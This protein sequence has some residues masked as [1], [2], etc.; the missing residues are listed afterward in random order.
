[1]RVAVIRFPGSNCDLDVLEALR[2][3]PEVSS[4][5]LWHSDARLGGYDAV[6]LPGGFSYA[7]R[8]RAGI[9]AAHSPVMERVERFAEDGG[10][11]LGICN[12]FQIL[13]E[14]GLLPGALLPNASLRFICRW[15]SLRVENNETPFT[16]LYEEGQVIR[17]PIAHS[18]GRYY[19]EDGELRRMEMERRV[20]FRYVD[21]EGMAS[22]KANPNGSARS[23]AGVTNKAGNVLGLMPHPERASD[24]LLSPDGSSDGR[25]LF[26]SML[27]WWRGRG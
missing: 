15:V 25:L 2:L 11:V 16:C 22:K 13:V 23:V 21:E 3:F 10:L 12:G 17:M 19:H 5:L 4:D 1:M 9:I 7:D 8:L 26:A 18:E 24:V 14:S 6:I 27:Q 20:A